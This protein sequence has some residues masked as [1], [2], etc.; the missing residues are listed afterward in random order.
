MGSAAGADLASPL[1][2]ARRVRV[3]VTKVAK[4]PSAEVSCLIGFQGFGAC[5][6]AAATKGAG[7]GSADAAG[8]LPAVAVSATSKGA[9]TG[10]GSVQGMSTS[11]AA[12]KDSGGPSS[13]IHMS[14]HALPACRKTPEMCSITL[15]VRRGC[16]CGIWQLKEHVRCSFETKSTWSLQAAHQEMMVQCRGESENCEM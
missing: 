4:E 11:A 9:A 1:Q 2:V 14:L 7:E 5:A 10:T 12:N 6:R 3:C 8:K 15:D 13:M 16:N